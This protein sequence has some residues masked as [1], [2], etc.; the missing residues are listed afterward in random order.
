MDNFIYYTPT[1]VYFGKDQELKIGDIIET[2]HPK[3][4]LIVY[5]SERL[6]NNG[7]IH[8][9]SNLIKEK[10]IDVTYFGGITPNPTLEKAYEGVKVARD[11]KVDFVL[12]IGGGSVLDTAKDIAHSLTNPDDDIW[13]YHLYIKYPTSSLHKG[14]ILTIAAAGSEMSASSVLTNSK[15]KEKNGYLSD[16]NRFDFVIEN[17]ELT[18]TVSKY[19]TACGIVDIG[20]HTIERYFDVGEGTELTDDLALSVIKNINKWGYEAYLNPL[21]YHARAN[22][23]WASSLAHNGLTH[24]GRKF[25]LVVHKLEHVLSAFYPDV[26]HGAGLAALWCSWARFT[27]TANKERFLTYVKE[28]WG[29]K[30]NDDEAILEGIKKQED[31]YKSIGM[32]TSLEELGVHPDDLEKMALH[33]SKNKTK[34][35]TE[36]FYPL[37]Y[38]EILKI[39]QLAFY[40]R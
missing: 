28:I 26:A 39:Y 29:V 40:K 38:D 20:M 22:M 5:G 6:M 35:I 25:N 15:T 36:T 17:P 10:G 9:I 18:Y 7:F 21:D 16:F 34:V 32:P 4:V 3:K 12:A 1:K 24:M 30:G 23:M 11:N 33:C 2:F 13:D 31:F 14:A 37:G 8:K 27:Y 19:Q